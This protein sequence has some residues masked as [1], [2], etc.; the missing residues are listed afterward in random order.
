[1]KKIDE[2]MRKLNSLHT[3]LKH[4]EIVTTDKAVKLEQALTCLES[5]LHV[6]QAVVEQ[7]TEERDELRAENEELRRNIHIHEGRL[8]HLLQS[9]TIRLFD[10]TDGR[11]D[12]VRDIKRLD[13]YA[14]PLKENDALMAPNHQLITFPDGDTIKVAKPDGGYYLITRDGLKFNS[15][16][17]NVL[18]IR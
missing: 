11:G 7:L 2:I 16:A 14:E 18:E 4:I 9:E 1:M 15:A 6:K 3:M 8:R 10:E 12:Y 5:Q 17:G 13:A